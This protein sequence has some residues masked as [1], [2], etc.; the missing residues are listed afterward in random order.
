[1][2]KLV[3][4]IALNSRKQSKLVSKIYQRVRLGARKLVK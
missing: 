2:L 3:L 1:M 4:Q